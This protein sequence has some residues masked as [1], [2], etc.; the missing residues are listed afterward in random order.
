MSSQKK[1]ALSG[2][3]RTPLNGARAIGPTDPQ[4][5]IEISVLLKHRR[6][7]VLNETQGPTLSHSDFS[8]RYGAHPDSI[9]K[10]K[11]F[12]AENHLQMIE[13]GDEV[14]RRTVV[15]AG[16]V[17]AMENA[18]NVTLHDYQ[19]ENGSYRGRTGSIHIPEDLESIIQGVFGLDDRLAAHPHFRLRSSAGAFGVRATDMA[20]TPVEVAKLYDYPDADG[21]GQTIGLIEL[22]GGFRPEDIQQ[23]FQSLKLTPPSVHAVSVDH[24]KNRPTNA[25]SAD[26]EVMLDI[27]VA[28][29]IAP[30]AKIV[31]YFAPNTSRGFQDALSTAIH[32]TKHNPS[33]VSISWGSA[34]IGWT[35]QSMQAFD[36]VAQEAA[37][38]GVTITVA[39]GDSG[40]SD[41]VNDGANHV[42][43]PA[44]SPHVLAAGGT[45]LVQ[46]NGAIQSETVW[47][48]GDQG[49]ATGGGYSAVFPRPAWQAAVVTQ[50]YRGVPDVS[51]DACP[52][53]GYEILV[54]GQAMAIGGTSAVAPLWAGLVALLNQAMGTRVGFLNPKLYAIDQSAAFHDITIGNNGAYS[55]RPGWDACTGLGSPDGNRILQALGGTATK[56]I[57][58]ARE[59]EHARN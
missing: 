40:S 58:D 42:D 33:A 15:L 4:Q 28:G 29:A 10:I 12:A 19:H 52:E 37:L 46:A 2:S 31:V 32:D 49:G 21:S 43:F 6:T 18:F 38:L 50:S 13:R 3:E 44:S 59:R 41:G 47:N 24:A 35:Q 51:G 34:E 8:E 1:I 16:T 26:G 36:Q 53:T 22:G 39:S 56:A 45:R 7:L 23:Y 14:L 27:E 5:L 11:Q 20:Y 17:A 48:D 57:M 54:D 55:A 25:Q 30:A 9:E